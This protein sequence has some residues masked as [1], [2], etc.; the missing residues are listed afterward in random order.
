MV[1]AIL[2]RY[3]E[4]GRERRSALTMALTTA[5]ATR[6]AEARGERAESAQHGGLGTRWGSAAS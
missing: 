6:I 5:L 1:R 2:D 4:H 3:R